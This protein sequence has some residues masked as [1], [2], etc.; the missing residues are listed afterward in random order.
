MVFFEIIFIILY[1][2][3]FLTLSMSHVIKEKTLALL[4]SRENLC[5]YGLETIVHHFLQ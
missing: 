4:T 3:S 1:V 5:G 2:M